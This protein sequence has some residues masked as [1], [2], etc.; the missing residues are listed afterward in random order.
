M[1]ATANPF[2][3][4]ERKALEARAREYESRGETMAALGDQVARFRFYNAAECYEG[5][6]KPGLARRAL[7]RAQEIGR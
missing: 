4:T 3:P 7:K 1:N 6:G 5:A 2:T